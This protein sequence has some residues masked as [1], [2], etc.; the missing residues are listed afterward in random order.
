MSHR[1]NHGYCRGEQSAWLAAG[2]LVAQLLSGRSPNPL[3]FLEKKVSKETFKQGISSPNII[4][5]EVKNYAQ[6]QY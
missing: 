2:S 4:Q 3:A 5:K 1:E 6:T